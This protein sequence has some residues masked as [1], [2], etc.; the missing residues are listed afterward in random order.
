MLILERKAWRQS[1]QLQ[2]LVHVYV[3]TTQS[4]F[5]L[6]IFRSLGK[7]L[8]TFESSGVNTGHTREV[9]GKLLPCL[10]ALFRLQQTRHDIVRAD[11]QTQHIHFHVDHPKSYTAWGWTAAIR[12]TPRPS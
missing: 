6:L 7:A 3:Y 2:C 4:Y 1:R 5:G 11:L 9:Q 12:A 10:K 8:Q